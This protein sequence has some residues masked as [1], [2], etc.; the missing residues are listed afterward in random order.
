[1]D[2]IQ[3]SGTEPVLRIYTEMPKVD[4]LDKIISEGMKSLGEA[5]D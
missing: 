4:E 2:F 3:T 1:M 5:N